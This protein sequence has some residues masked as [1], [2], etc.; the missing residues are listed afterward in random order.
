M[1]NHS[2]I[3]RYSEINN[4][5]KKTIVFRI[6][7]NAGF[8]SEYNNMI[9]GMLYCLKHRLKFRLSSSY[10]NFSETGWTDF[11]I[12]FCEQDHSEYHRYFNNRANSKLPV[13]TLI[14]RKWINLFRNSY[15]TQDIWRQFR[16]PKFQYF[17]FHFPSLN[18]DGQFFQASRELV[19]L[20]W[21][22]NSLINI[23]IAEKIKQLN[24]PD[25]FA[26]LHIRSGDKASEVELT[27][28]GMYVEKISNLTSLKNIFIATDDFNIVCDLEKRYPNYNFYHLTE[29][30][31]KGYDQ[32]SFILLAERQKRQELINLFTS[33]E[34]MA[35]SEMLVC[36]F[37]SNV[38][39]YMAMRRGLENTIDVNDRPWTVW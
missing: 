4:S 13:K 1:Q 38:G 25:K 18:I 33:V 34:I 3:N 19:K 39:L 36:T 28:V 16:N 21:Q 17:D 32:H 22:Y 37:T 27:E 26:A 2:L 14:K 35:L 9:F 11:F 10:A 31:A 23:Q 24:L 20:T 6:G 12:A 30:S 5:F 7:S 15:L 8:F 29:P